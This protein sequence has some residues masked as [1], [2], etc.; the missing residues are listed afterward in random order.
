MFPTPL[1]ATAA[2]GGDIPALLIAPFG[3]LLLLIAIMPLSP[4]GVKHLWDRFYH[5]VAVGLGLIVLAYY[6]TAIPGGGGEAAHTLGEYFSFIALIGSLFVVARSE[7]RR[8]GKE[9]RS[10]WSPYH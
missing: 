6:L 7:E 3:L 9:C 5:V 10:R 8:V 2:S 1:L 4:P